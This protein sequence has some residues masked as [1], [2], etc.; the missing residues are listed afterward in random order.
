LGA[1]CVFRAFVLFVAALAVIVVIVVVV[2]WILT[3]FRSITST[4]GT[5]MSVG[6]QHFVASASPTTKSPGFTI[7]KVAAFRLGT[8][9]CGVWVTALVIPHSHGRIHGG[10]IGVQIGALRSAALGVIHCRA[11][12]T[13]GFVRIC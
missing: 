7:R 5:T 12:M 1:F 4:V 10:T 11:H 2:R 8:F 3:T 13:V 9:S 6:T